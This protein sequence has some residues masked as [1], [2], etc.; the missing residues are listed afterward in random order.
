MANIRVAIDGPAGA[1]KS[2]VSREVARQLGYVY[3]D[4]GA[5]Y[6]AVAYAAIEKGMPLDATNADEL[7]ELANDVTI[8]FSQDVPPAVFL[9]GSDV[10]SKIRTPELGTAAS[11]VSQISGV[12]VAMVKQQQLLG[13]TDNIVMEGRDIGTVV[14]P[15]AEVKVYLTASVSERAR[16]R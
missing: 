13:K 8:T 14:F 15:D 7:T 9:N 3:L 4:S 16:R 11:M 12:R 1:G 10:S 6:R 5:M 2:T